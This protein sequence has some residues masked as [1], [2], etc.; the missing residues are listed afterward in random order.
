MNSNG[1]INILV[2]GT[3]M[4]VCGRGTDEYGTVLPAIFEWRRRNIIGDVCIAGTGARGI[5]IIKN[6]IK[7]LQL[8]MCMDISI[9]YFPKGTQSNQESY[10]EAI[11]KIPKPACAIVVVPDNLHRKIAGTVIEGG[12]HTL[13]VKPLAPT[14]KEV[15]ELVEIQ[16]RNKVYCAVEF[17]KRFDYANLKLKDTISQGLIGDLLYFLVEYS[18]RKSVPSKRFLGWVE[19]TNVFQYLGVHYVDIIYFVTKA[20]P[21]RAMAIGQKGWLAYKGIDTYDYI[22]GVIDWEMSSGKKF[23]SHILTNWIDPEKTSAM[24]DQKI[25]AIGTKGRFESDQ[26]RRGITIVSD[27]K[28][29]EEPNHYFCSPYGTKGDVY[30]QGYGIESIQQFLND[31]VQIEE[32]KLKIEDLEDKRP[33]FKQSII[34]TAVLEAVNKSLKQDG[35]WIK[36]EV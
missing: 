13:V 12:L 15:R 17:H 30:Y 19:K 16:K 20:K 35:K 6:K 2:I 10:K 34:S 36:I 24:S 26:K 32:G 21:R 4:Y 33:T 8:E 31:V 27:E 1:Q 14:L 7:G 9:K 22:T 28:G 5:N 11:H 25:K 29:I 18:Q 3:G 23:S